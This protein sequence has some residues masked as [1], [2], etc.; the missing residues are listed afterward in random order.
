MIPSLWSDQDTIRWRHQSHH[1]RILHL[2][3]PT[4][5]RKTFSFIMKNRF[6]LCCT[7]LKVQLCG[8]LCFP[9]CF[10]SM[11]YR[12]KELLVLTNQY[13]YHSPLKPDKENEVLAHQD[14]WHV[15]AVSKE[16]LLAKKR[17]HVCLNETEIGNFSVTCPSPTTLCPRD[18]S[19]EGAMILGDALRSVGILI[20]ILIIY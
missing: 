1:S 8:I 3:L 5:S 13:I 14:N 6:L 10:S 17:M 15:I 20:A 7:V 12:S 18:I 4:P 2:R 19:L 16:R 9:V 11:H